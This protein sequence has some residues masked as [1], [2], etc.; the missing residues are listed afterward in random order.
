[1]LRGWLKLHHLPVVLCQFCHWIT[2]SCALW[3]IRDLGPGYP[4]SCKARS[5]TE[6]TLT[7]RN[8]DHESVQKQKTLCHFYYAPMLNVSITELLF[9]QRDELESG[10]PYHIT[11]G[12]VVMIRSG[13]VIMTITV[14]G[15]QPSFRK[16]R[17]W[18]SHQM[19]RD[20]RELTVPGDLWDIWE[21][22]KSF[23]KREVVEA[24]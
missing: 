24:K 2:E 19:P 8:F 12:A 7:I 9:F 15:E 23:R 18:L 11:L 1:M 6:A 5:L 17:V 16:G 10:R 3:Y 22:G 21:L 14:R 20:I 13:P 4:A